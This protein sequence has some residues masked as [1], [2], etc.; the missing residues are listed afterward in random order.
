MGRLALGTV[1]LMGGILVSGAAAAACS[2][3]CIEGVARTLCSNIDEARGNP[4]ACVTAAGPVDCPRPALDPAPVLY[5]G[6]AGA[7]H[8]RAARLWDPDSGGYAV[9]AKI[10]ELDAAEA[11]G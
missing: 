10:C 3:Q 2:C 9:T 7:A 4:T 1:L 8:C 6:P 11:T 5:E